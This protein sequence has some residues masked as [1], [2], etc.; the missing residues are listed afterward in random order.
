MK[1]VKHTAFR[2]WGFE[3]CGGYELLGPRQ[4]GNMKSKA[5]F[6]PV[7]INSSAM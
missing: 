3:I 6:H 4:G 1:S 7:A 5:F 2:K